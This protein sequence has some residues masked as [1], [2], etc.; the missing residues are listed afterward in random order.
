MN[1]LADKTIMV[2]GSTSGM[3]K[4]MAVE[5]AR[6]GATL[7]LHGREDTKLARVVAEIRAKTSSERF[8][9]YTA[10]FLSL[11][12]VDEMASHI[13][14]E[15]PRLDV[16]INNAGIGTGSPLSK[17]EV[18]EDGYES[19][20]AVNYLA[21][22]LPTRRLLPLLK[23]SAP[24]RVVNVVSAGQQPIDF[25]DVMLERHFGKMRAYMQSKL[26]MIMMTFDMAAELDGTRVTVNALHPA[27]FMN[28]KM[29]RE[30]LIP[31]INSVRAGAEPTIRLAVASEVE[32]VTG[33]YFD[34]T[35]QAR[36]NSQAYDQEARRRLKVLSEQLTNLAG[37]K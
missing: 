8:R 10:N 30:A 1:D 15:E 25:S 19:R 9:V 32:G 6:R 29:V 7:L 3:G 36:A 20:F 31:P 14:R 33:E 23:K 35:R 11:R 5:L 27:K 2:T 4:H 17:R 37:T 13:L 34:G 12:Q 24:A 21:P 22:F 28:T 18:S 26:A 16:L